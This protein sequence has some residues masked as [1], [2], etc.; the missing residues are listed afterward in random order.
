MTGPLINLHSGKALTGGLDGAAIEQYSLGNFRTQRF[1]VEHVRDGLHRVVCDPMGS[2]WDVWRGSTDDGT[3]IVLWDWH[4][5]PNQLFNIV[6]V[7]SGE[8]YLRA[9]HSGKVAEIA[10]ASYTD[11]AHLIQ[12]NWIYMPNQLFRVFS[13]PI[14][15]GVSYK[16]MDISGASLDNGAPLVQWSGHR[17]TIGLNQR[18]TLDHAGG[19]GYRLIAA[20]SGK[21]LDVAGASLQNG[22]PIVQWDWHG[23]PNQRFRISRARDESD[24][25]Y[26]RITAVHSGKSFDVL[27]FSHDDGAPIV[28]WDW[29]GG[30]NQLWSF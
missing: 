19:P 6:D 8:Y 26:I 20:H 2:V 17:P 29:H 16:L 15:V 14:R 10:N 5:G 9:A 18:F 30:P 4:G 11:G 25:Y 28:Q 24:I 13:G 12:G 7:G 1:R 23:G 3:P 27:G 21:V 22:A